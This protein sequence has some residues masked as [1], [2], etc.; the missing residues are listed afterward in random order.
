[1]NSN[2]RLSSKLRIFCE[3]SAARREMVRSTVQMLDEDESAF[4]ESRAY[5]LAARW[6]RRDP[7]AVTEVN[8]LF[9][10]AGLDQEAIAAQTLAVKFDADLGEEAG[11][12]SMVGSL[13]G[14]PKAPVCFSKHLHE[15]CKQSERS[16]QIANGFSLCLAVRRQETR[17]DL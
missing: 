14:G 17:V 11:S 2:A 4:R 16:N 6:A 10:S 7:T 9:K 1:V 5:I 8:D 15:T 12:R 13:P 3:Q